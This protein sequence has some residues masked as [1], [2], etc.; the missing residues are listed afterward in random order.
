MHTLQCLEEIL[1]CILI[2]FLFSLTDNA[3]PHN[4]FYKDFSFS[5]AERTG[6]FIVT[7]RKT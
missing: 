7:R 5:L 6:P 4:S 2:D 1:V 3:F